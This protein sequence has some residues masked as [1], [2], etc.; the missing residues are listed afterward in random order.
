M[1][2]LR[3]EELENINGG[4]WLNVVSGVSGKVY[5]AV[6][7]ESTGEIIGGAIGGVL[8]DGVGAILGA[9]AGSTIGGGIG[10]IIGGEL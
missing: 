2:G 4:N 3:T 1:I 6:K 9:E 10:A 7:D 5:N 8:G